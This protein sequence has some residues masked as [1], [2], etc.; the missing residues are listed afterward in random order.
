MN[1]H[2]DGIMF[3]VSKLEIKKG[4]IQ[5][6]HP[7]YKNSTFNKKIRNK[8]FFAEKSK[9]TQKLLFCTEFNRNKYEIILS[10]QDINISNLS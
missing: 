9:R 5:V 7:V 1:S 3:T 10:K 6:E 4:K 8:L 2:I